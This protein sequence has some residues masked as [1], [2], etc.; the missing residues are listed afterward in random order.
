M[1]K[2]EYKGWIH[3]FTPH[4]KEKESSGIL[5]SKREQDGL[6]VSTVIKQWGEIRIF[7]LAASFQYLR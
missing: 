3:I 1:I 2:I 4:T 6:E 5:V 7:Q